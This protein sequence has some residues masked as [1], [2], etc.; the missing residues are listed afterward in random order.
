MPFNVSLM[1]ESAE[2][3]SGFRRQFKL[4]IGPENPQAWE[5]KGN[6]RRNTDGFLFH[7]NF[8]SFV[9]NDT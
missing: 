2:L 4:P 5:V 8:D 1:N 3:G 6:L 9:V 7:E